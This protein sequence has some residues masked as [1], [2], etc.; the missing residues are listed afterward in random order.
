M[1][2]LKGIKNFESLDKKYGLLTV[3]DIKK[4]D[5]RTQAVCKCDCG[6]IRNCDMSYLKRSK[7][8]ICGCKRAIQSSKA[9]K[10]NGGHGKSYTRLYQI[11]ENMKQRCLNKN[12]KRYSYYGGCGISICDEW[13]EFVNFNDWSINNGYKDGLTIDRKDNFGNYTPENCR[14]ITNLEQQSNTRKTVR[15]TYNGETH[16]VSEWARRIG[17]ERGVILYKIKTGKPIE[18]ILKPK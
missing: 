4:I 17:V 6:N 14:W 7:S 1:G 8:T 13:I 9:G 3:I 15:L 10:C 2:A 16:H 12:Y 5:N 11:W 18:E